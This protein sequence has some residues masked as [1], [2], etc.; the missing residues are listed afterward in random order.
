MG[1]YLQLS[2]NSQVLSSLRALPSGF[3]RGSFPVL[4]GEKQAG[5][6]REAQEGSRSL[7]MMN[8]SLVLAN[9]HLFMSPQGHIVKDA[10]AVGSD[11]ASKR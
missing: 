2:G 5:S 6:L 4:R 9:A 3:V 11:C 8:F 10:G 7:Q 1:C